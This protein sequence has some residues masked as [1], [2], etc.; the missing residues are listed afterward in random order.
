MR[1]DRVVTT[2]AGSPYTCVSRTPLPGL[3]GV[4]LSPTPI[5]SAGSPGG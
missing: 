2:V 3:G 4:E 5:P 1:T